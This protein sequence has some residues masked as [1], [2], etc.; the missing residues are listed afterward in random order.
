MSSSIYTLS[1]GSL[2][3]NCYLIW[4]DQTYEALIIDP[5]DSGDT[6][7]DKILELK[8]KPIAIVL[9]HAH[10]DHVLGLLETK[11]NFSVPI[12]IHQK[13]ESLLEKTQASAQHWLQR[14]VDPSP[15]A[16]KFVKQGDT[17]KYGQEQLKVIETPGH[18]PGSICLYDDQVIFTGDTL[19]KNAIGRTDFSYSD[20]SEMKKSLKALFTLSGKLIVYPGHGITTTIKEEANYSLI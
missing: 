15:P 11:L 2:D 1:L 6:I 12:I 14:S 4:C 19:F 5:A 7:S 18:T 13:D 20:P 9:T 8:L 10:F 17:I 16:D 3:T